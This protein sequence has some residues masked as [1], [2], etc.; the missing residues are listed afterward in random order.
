LATDLTKSNKI[1]SY[2]IYLYI[3]RRE[4][5]VNHLVIFQFISS[6]SRLTEFTG[7][8]SM[9]TVDALRTLSLRASL[10]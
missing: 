7:T 8:I 3:F 10:N 2:R 4:S 6:I 9:V 1:Q 5:I